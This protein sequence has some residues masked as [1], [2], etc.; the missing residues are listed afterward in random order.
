MPTKTAFLSSLYESTV[1]RPQNLNESC[2]LEMPS[3]LQWVERKFD[4]A[5]RPSKEARKASAGKGKF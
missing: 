5:V 3:F 2:V 4:R 1:P